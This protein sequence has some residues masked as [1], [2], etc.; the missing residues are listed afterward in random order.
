MPRA[1]VLDVASY[2]LD[3]RRGLTT[4]ELQKLV[5]YAQAWSLAWDGRPLFDEEIQ[6]WTNGPVVPRLFHAHRKWFMV[7]GIQGGRADRVGPEDRAKVDAVLDYYGEH[8]A[9][10]LVQ[11]THEDQPWRQARGNL[12]EDAASSVPIPHRDLG[13]FYTQQHVMGL[14][15]PTR[16]ATTVVEASLN[17]ALDEADRQ[18]K[19]WRRTLDWLA[20]R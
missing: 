9:P 14:P 1:S 16:P 2:I 20:V 18:M 13:R 4:F 15:G 10:A 8:G 19:K 11:M 17:D 12:S 5:Y 7:R 3:R 6:A